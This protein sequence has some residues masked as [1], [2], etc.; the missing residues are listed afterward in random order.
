MP[1]PSRMVATLIDEKGSSSTVSLNIVLPSSVTMTNLQEIGERWAED[2]DNVTGCQV[3]ALAV[4]YEVDL[5]DPGLSLKNSPDIGSDIEE[6]ARFSF[7]TPSGFVTEFRIPGFL[8]SLITAGTRAVN[9]LAPAVV[10]ILTDVI[11]GIGYGV[12]VDIDASDNRGED[13]S[14]LTS[15]VEQFVRSRIRRF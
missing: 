11:A 13:I 12:G 15:A 10:E 14:R 4:M 2:L 1:L 7:G 6:G 9:V 8:E 5:S 3:E